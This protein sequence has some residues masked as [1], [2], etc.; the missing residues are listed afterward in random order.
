MR[1]SSSQALLFGLL[2]LVIASVF[3]L[4]QAAFATEE[5]NG[6]TYTGISKDRSCTWWLDESKQVSKDDKA[7]IKKLFEALE[8]KLEKDGLDSVKFP[9]K[10][11]EIEEDEEVGKEEEKKELTD[12]Q[13]KWEEDEVYEDPETCP[14]VIIPSKDDLNIAKVDGVPTGTLFVVRGTFDDPRIEVWRMK[15]AKKKDAWTV[16]GREIEYSFERAHVM[17]VKKN[18]AYTF[19]EI[20]IDHDLM[21]ISIDEGRFYPLYAGTKIIGGTVIGKGKMNYRPPTKL[22][23]DWETSQEV[24]SLRR[25]TAEVTRQ[26]GVDELKDAPLTKIPFY[27]A[28]C[29]FDKYVKLSGLQKFEITDKGELEEAEKLIK[30]EIDWLAKT[31][32]GVKLPYKGQPEGEKHTL[33]LYQLPDYDELCDLYVYGPKY[34]WIGYYDYPADQGNQEEIGLY[35]HREKRFMIGEEKKGGGVCAYNRPEQRESLT[36]R[37]AEYEPTEEARQLDRRIDINIGYKEQTVDLLASMGAVEFFNAQT[38]IFAKIRATLELEIT[39]S[40]ARFF[41]IGVSS[42]A[43][44]PAIPMN[45][46]K[47]VDD[48]GLD[49]LRFGTLD[50]VY[51]PLALGQRV[52]FTAE[53]EGPVCARLFTSSAY[54][55][56][57]TGWAPSYGYFQCTP[58]AI[59]MGVPTPHTSVSVGAVEER[60]TE[61][62]RNFSR[63]VS[64]ECIRMIGFVYSNY[65]VR[66]VE[67]TKPNGEPLNI[68]LYY[69]PKMRYYISLS[70]FD[71]FAER[72]RYAED[73]DPRR[74][75]K[76][77]M[78]RIRM[79]ERRTMAPDSIVTEF[80]SILRFQQALYT[81]L[82]YRKIAAVQLPVFSGY[83]QGFPTMLTLDGTSFFSAG[84]AA[85]HEMHPGRWGAEFWSH[86]SGHQYW[87]HVIMWANPRDQWWSEAFTEQ[88]CAMYMQASRSDTDYMSKLNDWRRVALIMNA[89]G[90]EAPMTLGGSRL[91]RLAWYG[92]FY[93]KG[94]YFVHMIR[95]MIGDKA[96]MSYERNLVKSLYWKRATTSDFVNVLEQTIGKDN[97]LA[98]FGKDNMQ[99]FFDQ[100][101]Y[102]TGI[103]SYEYGY[104][105]SGN[106][107]KIRIKHIDVQFRVR[108][109]I[110]VYDKSG[111][112]YAI[113]IL[114]TG[115]KPIEEFELK[116]R[117]PAKKIVLDEFGAV[118][119]RKI[120][121]VKYSKIK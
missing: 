86:E 11:P 49:I 19:K 111:E 103:P 63:W 70:D 116:L 27:F 23:K 113:P 117:G 4:S 119:T 101:I 95:Q 39:R 120:K 90:E 14:G 115:E 21:H 61:G 34:Q 87:G 35:M 104:K 99:W 96:F 9:W 106:T 85:L 10:A 28:P 13:K 33:M 71:S 105:I 38:A 68:S 83:G 91:T 59:V 94:P 40:G 46:S 32:F 60:W 97:M 17:Y 57:N 100:W 84:D 22:A 26:K 45:I 7:A 5:E 6:G 8:K 31:N 67:V 44:R 43:T 93:C 92:L 65:S 89:K 88:Q 51:P 118:L 54:T 66:E 121:K 37:E 24:D 107:A 41:R 79:Q 50:L 36:R 2:A 29:N 52:K 81:S 69:Y 108:I 48:R 55:S 12:E 77:D 76:K 3:C 102:G 75:S 20:K 109:P 47:V 112:K 78:T 56:G 16:T 74:R 72:Q 42:L 80:E 53:Y 18:T 64:D 98:L 58:C 82:P 114:L 25:R 30:S 62:N 73:D 110:W 15:L 1:I